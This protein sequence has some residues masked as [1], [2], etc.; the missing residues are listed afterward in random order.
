MKCCRTAA[1]RWTRQ[2]LGTDLPAALCY[3]PTVRSVGGWAFLMAV[4]AAG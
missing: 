2:A 3:D 1:S 4:E